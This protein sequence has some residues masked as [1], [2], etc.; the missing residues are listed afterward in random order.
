MTFVA[1]PSIAWEDVEHAL[2]DWAQEVT[3]LEVVWA[4]EN[5]PQPTMPYVLLDWLVLP[6]GVGDDYF[7]QQEDAAASSVGLVLEG[8]RR[9][10]LNVQV[11]SASTGPGRSAPY[12]VD[13][14]INSLNADTINLGYFAPNRMAVWGNEPIDKG[15]FAMD[16][17][18]ISRAGVDLI[19]GF[20]A[21]VGTPGETIGTIRNASVNATLS[22]PALTATLSVTS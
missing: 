1:T 13:L 9:G 3:G 7:S 18:A 10:T 17:T 15:A 14:L 21:G 20:A 19:L 16:K 2:V 22:S 5:A 4:E 6:S 8:V 11:L 12:F